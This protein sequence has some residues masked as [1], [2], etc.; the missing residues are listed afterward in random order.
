M[1][2]EYMC[3]C[4]THLESEQNNF[5]YLSFKEG[6]MYSLEQILE[7]SNIE[8]VHSVSFHE[9]ILLNTTKR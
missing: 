2:C 4:V 7:L 5:I 1:A 6:I 8:R 3:I 9:T